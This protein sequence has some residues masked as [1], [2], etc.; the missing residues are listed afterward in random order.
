MMKK[1]WKKPELIVLVRS[2]PAEN[3][4][5]NCKIQG[6]PTGPLSSGGVACTANPDTGEPCIENVNS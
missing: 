2:M 6:Y 3:V 5:T 1:K 4:L